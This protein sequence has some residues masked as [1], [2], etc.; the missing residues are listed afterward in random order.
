MVYTNAEAY[1]ML[2]IYFECHEN[3]VIAS[4][5]YNITY[6][7]R[8]PQSR[9]V[10]RR[11]VIRLR[12]TGRVQ[13]IPTRE[14]RRS[15]RNEDNIV[16]VLTCIEI[17]PQVSTR[18]ISRMM[19][20]PQPTIVRILNQHRLHPYHVALHQSLTVNDFESRLNFCNWMQNM[21]E[22]NPNFLNRILWT[23][24]ATFKSNG[25]VNLHNMHFYAQQ[26][27]HWMRTVDNQHRWSVNVWCGILDGRIIGPHVFNGTVTGQTFLAFLI[28]T[29]PN[30]LDDVPLVDV[31]NMWFQMDGCPAHYAAAVRNH[32]TVEFPDRWIGRGSVFPWPPRSPDLTCLD[33]FLWGRIKDIVYQNPPTTREDMILRIENAV[34]G[35]SR[36]EIESAVL[37]TRG[38]IHDC[39]A[40]NGRQFEHLR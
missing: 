22:E 1:D 36:A 14:R 30:L 27:P 11:L 40:N 9:K 6:P 3:E 8:Q 37:S 31:L 2:R 28:N 25:R 23:D 17:N 26:N 18:E 39:I 15:V 34:N 13:S 7:N 19:G 12:T 5:T 21:V 29:L 24:E 35:I 38:R 20:I 10:F 4:R 16:N 32:L 33:F